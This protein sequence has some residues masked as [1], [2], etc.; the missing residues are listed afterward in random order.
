ML[1]EPNKDYAFP[2]FS[3]FGTSEGEPSIL[4]HYL[5]SGLT[6]LQSQEVRVCQGIDGDF[7]WSAPSMLKE[8]TSV[9]NVL[10]DNEERWGDYTT[11]Q[12]RFSMTLLKFGLLAVLAKPEVTEHGL[13]KW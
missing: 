11:V 13:G 10:Q 9:I 6:T 8:G 3:S 5:S 4:M 12:R 2:S 1:T 7:E